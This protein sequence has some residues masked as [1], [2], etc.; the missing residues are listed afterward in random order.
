MRKPSQIPDFFLLN[1]DDQEAVYRMSSKQAVWSESNVPGFAAVYYDMCSRNL[2]FRAFLPQRYQIKLGVHDVGS[3]ARFTS[4]DSL[5]SL[6][7]EILCLV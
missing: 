5:W 6:C 1:K 2:S 3:F 7:V 4:F